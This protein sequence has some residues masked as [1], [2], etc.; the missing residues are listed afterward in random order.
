MYLSNRSCNCKNVCHLIIK[1]L[2]NDFKCLNI[3]NTLICK[4]ILNLNK[5]LKFNI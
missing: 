5:I 1:Y 3:V 4:Y 2:M